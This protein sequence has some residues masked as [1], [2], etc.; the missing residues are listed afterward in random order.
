MDEWKAEGGCR[1]LRLQL[2]HIFLS[3]EP[4]NEMA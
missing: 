4:N 1:E 3:L 2:D